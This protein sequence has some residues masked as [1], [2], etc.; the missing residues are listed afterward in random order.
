M[1]REPPSPIVSALEP[2]VHRAGTAAGAA[3][4][5][6]EEPDHGH[7]LL[8]AAAAGIAIAGGPF[9]DMAARIS[10]LT[11]RVNWASAVPVLAYCGASILMTLTNKFVLSGFGFTMNFLLL[12]VQCLSVVALLELF[13]WLGHLQHRPFRVA[14]ARAWFPVSVL[15]ALMIYTGSKAL[16]YLSISI[17]TVFKNTTIIAIAYAERFFLNGAPVT[18]EILLSF[19]LMILSSII[20]GWADLTS[21]TGGLKKDAF[22][23]GKGTAYFWMFMN[24]LTAAA[25]A[26]GMRGAMKQV[27]FKEFD[28]VFYNN[29]LATPLLFAASLLLES[30]Q[31]RTGRFTVLDPSSISLA[32]LGWAIAVSSASGFAISY[33]SSWCV[34]MTSSTTFSMAGALNKLPIAVAGMV[35]FGDPVTPG[36]VLGV[37]LAFLAG[38]IYTRAKSAQSHP[39]AP[40]LP[41]ASPSP[42][43]KDIGDLIGGGRHAENGDGIAHLVRGEKEGR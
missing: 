7:P 32:G 18:G 28:T 25:Y 19:G 34:R 12:A 22:G 26:V 16:Q 38:I 24:C 30:E 11:S 29:L 21:G 9:A 33:C 43:A 3:T 42:G 1:S 15:L 4:P 10:V 6:P 39:P 13:H 27:K 35:V 8:P 14:E 5:P 36:S 23:V 37:G 41:V 17:F 31:W 2:P 20:A 40:V